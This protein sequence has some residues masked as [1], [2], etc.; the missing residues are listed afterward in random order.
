MRGP[1]QERPILVLAAILSC[2]PTPEDCPPGSHAEADALCHLD[3]DTAA[4]A[5]SGE[6]AAWEATGP[7]SPT[8][9]SVE[10]IRT[11]QAFATDMVDPEDVI[12]AYKEVFAHRSPGCPDTEDPDQV[13]AN[14]V[15]FTRGCTAEDGSTFEGQGIFADVCAME[16]DGGGPAPQRDVGLLAQFEMSDPA[17]QSFLGGGGMS[18]RCSRK[19]DGSGLCYTEFGGSYTWEGGTGWIRGGAD[20]SLIVEHSWSEEERWTRLQGGVGLPDLDVAFDDVFIDHKACAGKPTGTLRVRDPSGWWHELTY[21]EDCSGCGTLSWH[22][23]DEG[24]VCLDL[25]V[26]LEDALTG[27]EQ[28]CTP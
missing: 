21:A 5:D 28:P 13:G 11:E 24:T 26:Y 2:A 15:W 27:W 4:P 22:G 18:L 17:G 12:A 6:E 20:V 7:D 9:D 25:G 23:Q 10:A 1:P 16:D 19:A 14:G 3:E 8:W